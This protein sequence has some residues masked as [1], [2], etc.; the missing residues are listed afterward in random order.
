MTDEREVIMKR[1]LYVL[2]AAL[3]I[4]ASVSCDRYDDGRPSKDLRSEF[5][6]MYPDAFDVEWDWDGTYWEVSFETGS[7]PDGVEHE[8][9]YDRSGQWIR[10]STEMLLSAVPQRIKDYLFAD[11][12]YTAASF[13]DNDAEY[14]ET[15]SGNF[16]RFDIYSGDRKIEVDVNINGEVT[17]AR[18]DF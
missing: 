11:P 5:N 13:A 15:P 14:I 16:Y 17:F 4:F 6:R 9:W 18:Y 12:A 3:A 10:T 7:R 1:L 8:A 2:T